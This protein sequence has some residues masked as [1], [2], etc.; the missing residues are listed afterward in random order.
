[1]P[2]HP[3]RA[4]AGQQI[5]IWG[6]NLNRSLRAQQDFTNHLNPNI[7]DI[8]L[9]QEP[10]FD[11]RGVSRATRAFVSIYPT[12]HTTN[13]KDTRSM[14]LVN[15]RLPSTS[16]STIAIPSPDITAIELVGTFGTVRII[17]VYNDCNHN[18]AI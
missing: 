11:F 12:T 14:I 17:N 3:T 10:Y 16:W 1:M 15:T 4:S 9:I 2:E 7:Y 13:Q 8:A 6:Q 5:R 18:K